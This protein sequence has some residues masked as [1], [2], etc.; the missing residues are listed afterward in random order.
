MILLDRVTKVYPGDSKP[1]LDNVSLH[2]APNEFV[3]LVGKSGAGKS[4]LM[5]MITKE[6]DPSAGKIV[7][8][9]IDL[10]YIN[11][12]ILINDELY[13]VEADYADARA[14]LLGILEDLSLDLVAY[15]ERRVH[16]DRVARMYACPFDKF[17]YARYE[18]IASVAYCIDFHF[19]TQNVLVYQYRLVFIDLY[20]G[21]KIVPELRLIADDLH[22][23][24]AKNE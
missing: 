5:K 6:E 4:T 23:A 24:S 3:F 17:H 7:V 11:F 18:Y 22:R 12:V 20:R 10:D 19:L 1:A 2:I 21:L 13:V 14:E 8:G 16:R 15:R 9:G